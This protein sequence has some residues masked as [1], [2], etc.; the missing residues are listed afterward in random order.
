MA[1]E[2]ATTDDGCGCCRPE[3]KSSDD[4]VRDLLARRATVEER[5]QRLEPVTAGAA[6]R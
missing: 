6:A 5:L 2:T 3:T 1:D 4:V